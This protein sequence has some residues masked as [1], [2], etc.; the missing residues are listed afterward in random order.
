MLSVYSLLTRPPE[1]LAA[2]LPGPT[3]IIPEPAQSVAA[4]ILPDE[5]PS[6]AA[7]SERQ[8]A[9][10]TLPVALAALPRPGIA[11]VAVLPVVAEAIAL[12]ETPV[13]LIGPAGRVYNGRKLFEPVEA[14]LLARTPASPEEKWIEV[15]LSEQVVTAWEGNVP[16]MSFLTS[17]GLPDTP[18]VQ[19]EYHIY[20]KL[21]STLMSGPGYYLPD[22]PYTM[23][24]Y[25]GYGLHGAYWHN[26][27]GQPMSHGCVNLS[28]ENSK[29]LFEWADPVIPPGQTQ[30]V[31]SADNPGTLVLVHE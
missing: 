11:A 21:E 14:S 1:T 20:W 17:T 26:N 25:N 30:V 15:D 19:G 27:F 13:E 16:V 5:H 23:Y 24:F 12:P 18:T 4:E 6:A 7:L 10:D 8:R 9:T 3:A 22:V 28:N 31:S 29:S 2:W